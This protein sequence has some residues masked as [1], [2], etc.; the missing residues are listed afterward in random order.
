MRI[1]WVY[2]FK[3]GFSVGFTKNNTRIIDKSIPDLRGD[4]WILKGYSLKVFHKQISDDWAGRAAHGT[5]FAL[6]VKLI[7]GNEVWT[8]KVKI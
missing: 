8:V 6:L 3:E 7:S 1:L 4:G 2:V 5:T